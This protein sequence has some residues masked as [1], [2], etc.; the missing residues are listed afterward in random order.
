ME[1]RKRVSMLVWIL[2]IGLVS[3]NMVVVPVMANTF[4]DQ[5]NYYSPDPNTRSPPSGLSVSLCSHRS[6]GGSPPSH[7]SHHHHPTPSTPSPGNCENPPPD[8]NPPCGSCG[9]PSVPTTPS[10]PSVPTPS[11]PPSGGGY[12][13]PTP[14]GGGSPPTPVVDNPP[15]SPI[16]VPGTPYSPSPPYTPDPN[17]PFSCNYWR[18][19]PGII[20]G[21]LGWWGTL[22]SAFG[23]V[24]SFPG[25]GAS[26]S[27]LQALSNT[28]NDGYGTLYREGTASFLNSMINNRFP[29]T[30]RQVR[31]NFIAGLGSNKAA[32]AQGNIFKLANE[33]KVKPR[34]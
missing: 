24:T 6:H 15:P 33:G 14:T 17:S 5:K 16:F 20:W 26:T 28:R 32:A 11:N 21:I 4:E 23:P 7:G 13:P 8:H 30:T 1:K 18:T 3:H 2:V 34:A 22:G 31:D 10:T 25:A 9:T 12:Y 19:H 29:F 27:L